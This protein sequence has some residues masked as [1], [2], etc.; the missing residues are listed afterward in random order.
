[1]VSTHVSTNRALC[2]AVGSFLTENSF[3]TPCPVQMHL[4]CQVRSFALPFALLHADGRYL[5]VVHQL[6][7]TGLPQWVLLQLCRDMVPHLADASISQL[8]IGT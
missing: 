7:R 3:K 4:W 5:Q 1:M 8:F 6:V 2:V